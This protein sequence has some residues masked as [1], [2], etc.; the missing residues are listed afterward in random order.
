MYNVPITKLL[1]V[2]YITVSYHHMF[3]DCDHKMTCMM[4]T[5]FTTQDLC[6]F[7]FIN[8]RKL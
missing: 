5:S 3:K 4:K 8:I 7:L 1:K 2:Q 6:Y